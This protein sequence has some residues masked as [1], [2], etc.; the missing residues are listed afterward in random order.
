M[1]KH[2]YKIIYLVNPTAG[3]ANTMRGMSSTV[4]LSFFYNYGFSLKGWDSITY[5]FYFPYELIISYIN[6]SSYPR[7]YRFNKTVLKLLDNN[8]ISLIL[9]DIHGFLPILLYKFQNS[10]RLK[11]LQK[12]YSL[13][14]INTGIL[15]SIVYK[16]LFKPSQVI[17]G[18]IKIFDW[19]KKGKTVLGIHIRSGIFGN[20]YTEKY[21]NNRVNLER[22]YKKSEIIIAKFNLSYVFPISD[23]IEYVN[24][25]KM[26]FGRSLL[27]I[28][29]EGDI[30][31]SKFSLYNPKIN[32][33]AI[34][35]VTEFMLLSSCDVIL[36]TKM[37]SFS[38]ES[39]NRLLRTCYVI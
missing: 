17:N 27:D 15:N 25:M 5:Y 28:Q 22:Y 16:E 26:H 34:R 10:V 32:G 23:N 24:E 9:T 14:E 13:K 31:H 4:Y 11:L 39:C 37:S 33:N 6:I 2:H 36:G 38:Y 30:I 35:I 1:N 20:N 21:F 29:V 8:N 12:Y 7:L 19:K 3:L 18:Y